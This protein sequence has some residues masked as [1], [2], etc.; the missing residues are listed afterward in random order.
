[1]T[2]RPKR[3]DHSPVAWVALG[4]WFMGNNSHTTH[5]RLALTALLILASLG[6]ALGAAGQASA[7]VFVPLPLQVGPGQQYHSIQAAIDNASNGDTIDVAPGIY[8]ETLTLDKNLTLLG[9][10]NGIP[11]CGRIATETIINASSGNLLTLQGGSAG[12][13]IDG[14]TFMGG[15]KQLQSTSGPIDDVQILNN[16]F[17]GF[18]GSAIFLNDQGK[19]ITIHQN[20]IDGS[21]TTGSGGMLHLDTDSFSGMQITNNCLFNASGRTG[22]FV[23]GSNNVDPSADRNPLIANN[24]FDGL[25]TGANLGHNA[26][27]GG[28]IT[29]NTFSNN[30]YDGLQGG[31]QHTTISFNKFHDNGRFGIDL[32]SFGSTNVN[33]G[34]Q[35]ANV[36]EN[37]FS[38]NGFSHDGAGIILS[39][40]QASGTIAT[41]VVHENNITGNRQGAIYTGSESVDLIHNWWGDATGPSGDG[42]GTGDAVSGSNIEYDPWL[43][44]PAFTSNISINGTCAQPQPSCTEVP[45]ECSERTYPLNALAGVHHGDHV[46]EDRSNDPSTG[47]NPYD[48]CGPMT[49]TIPS[50][51]HT[52]NGLSPDQWI[53]LQFSNSTDNVTCVYHDSSSHHDH[54]SSQHWDLVGCY[55]DYNGATPPDQSS[56][57]KGGDSISA[58]HVQLNITGQKPEGRANAHVNLK[59]VCGDPTPSC[60]QPVTCEQAVQQGLL[61]ADMNS[62]GSAVIHNN[63][64]TT[65]EVGIASYNMYNSLN[66]LGG[67]G[68]DTQTLYDYMLANVSKQSTSELNVEIPE[69]KAQV[70]VFCFNTTENSPITHFNQEN[71]TWY[72]GVGNFINSTFVGE[73]YCTNQT[74]PSCQQNTTTTIIVS[75][76]QAMVNG[77]N[78]V[79]TW[80]STEYWSAVIP[81][82]TW[83]WSSYYVQDPRNGAVKNFTRTFTLPGNVTDANLMIAV[84]DYYRVWLNGNLIVTNN[85]PNNFRSSGQDYLD[86]FSSYLH[87]GSNTVV[88]EV[89]NMA[90]NT[91]SPTDNPAGLLYRLNITT[92]TCGGGN[93]RS[94]C[95]D[96]II[97]QETEQCDGSAPA[98]YTCTNECTLERKPLFTCN[99]DIAYLDTAA[100]NQSVL[101]SVNTTTGIGTLSHVFPEAMRSVV[102]A[103]HNGTLYSMLPN[104]SNT[105]DLIILRADGTI[106][107][108]GPTGLS[109][110]TVAMEFA[111]NGTLYAMNENTNHLYEINTDT[112]HA[113]YLHTF[114]PDSLGVS[115]GDLAVMPN[116]TLI[117]LRADGNVYGIDLNNNYTTTLL[118][119]LGGSSFTSL[120]YVNETFYGL[121]RTNDGLYRFTLDPFNGSL[122]A[123]NVGPFDFGDATTCP[124]PVQQPTDPV[125]PILECVNAYGEGNYTAYFG[126]LN[127]NSVNITIPIGNENKITGGGLSGQDQGQPTVFTPGRT[128]YYPNASFS[129]N[130][131]GTNM[132]WTLKGP[133]GST[134]TSTASANSKACTPICGD[135][136]VEAGEQ[137]DG[138]APKGFVCTPD[139]QLKVDT[140]SVCDPNIQ[141]VSNGGFETPALASGEWDIFPNGTAGLDWNVAWATNITSFGGH[142]RP[143]LANMEIHNNV[144]GQGVNNTQYT[145]LDSDWF[146]HNLSLTG[147]PASVKIWEDLKT[148]PNATYNISFAFSPRPGTDAANNDLL[149]YWNGHLVDTISADGSSLKTTDW[150]FYNYSLVA[151]SN[152]TPIMFVDNGTPDGL[153][154]Y[155]D[156]VS[157]TCS[158]PA[159]ICG[160]GIIERGETCDDGN[161]VSGD[162]CSSTCQIE[163]ACL[164]HGQTNT[165]YYNSSYKEWYFWHYTPDNSSATTRFVFGPGTPLNNGSAQLGVDHKSRAAILTNMYSGTMLRDIQTL[166]YSTYNS[167]PDGWTVPFM[168]PA[169]T[170]VSTANSSK[171]PQLFFQPGLAYNVTNNTWQTWDALSN[172]SR[173]WYF[174][175]W[176]SSRDCSLAHPCTFNEVL[177]NFPD[178]GGIKWH[179]EMGFELGFWGTHDFTGYVD[180]FTISTNKIC[181]LNDFEPTAYCGDG[182]VNQPSE[183]CDG[184]APAGWTC[185]QQCQLQAPVIPI[186]NA[187]QI[188]QNGGFESPLVNTSQDWNIFPDGTAGLVWNV[189]W[190]SNQTTY[191]NETRPAIANAELQNLYPAEN[192]SQYAELDSDWDGPTGSL[193]GEP[194]SVTMSQVLPTIA[195]D[196]Y[197]VAFSF[198]PRPNTPASDNVLVVSWEGSPVDVISAAGGSSVNWT[199]YHLHLNAT[200]N[201][202][203]LSFTD[204]GTPDS[205]GTLLDGV[206]AVCQPR[207]PY[208]GNGI[209]DPGEQ[210]DGS[211]PKGFTCTSNCTIEVHTE[212]IPPLFTCSEGILFLDTAPSNESRLYTVNTTTGIGTLSHVFG[213]AMRSVVAANDNGT[214]YSML[215]NGSNTDGL[216]ILHDDGTI[217]NIGPTGLPGNTVAMEFA[218]DGTLYAMNQNTNGLYSVDVNTGHATLLHTFAPGVQGGDL[219]VTPDNMLVYL[220][221]DGKVYGV[222]LNDNY[223]TTLLGS[224][225]WS[226]FT[227]LGY[228]NGT[229]YGLSFNDNRMYSFTLGPFDSS[230]VAS[231]A[232]P[233]AYGDATSCPAPEPQPYVCEPGTQ[234][235]T[236]GGFEY[237]VVNNS[238]EWDI[239]PSG[240]SG[241]GWS[242]AWVPGPNTYQNE[243]RPDVANVELQHDVNGWLAKQGEQYAEL[244]SDW[245]GPN[246]S[247]SGEPAN[248]II[249]QTVPTALN[250]SY[251]LTFAFS[252]RPGS[253]ASTNTLQ[254]YF[255]GQ[256]VANITANG[257]NQTDWTTYGYNLVANSSNTTLSFVA[258]GTS[259]SLGTFLDNVSLTCGSTEPVCG[260][261]VLEQGEQCDDGNNVSGDGCSA[262]CQIETP[263]PVC[264]QQN[265]TTL[266]VSDNQTMVDGHNAVPTWVAGPWTSLPNATWIWNQTYVAEPRDG[267]THNFTRT[268]TLPGNVTGASL[269]IAADN[270]YRF[271]VN[272]ALVGADPSQDNYGSADSYTNVSSYLHAGSNTIVF[273][274]EN[275][276]W[277]TDSP[278][279]NPAGLLYRLNVTTDTCGGNGLPV[280]TPTNVTRMEAPYPASTVESA[281]QGLT[282]GGQSVRPQRSNPTQGLALE[283]THSESDFYT[284]GFGGNITVGFHYPVMNGPGPDVGV[285]ET[286][287]KTN[288]YPNETADVYASNDMVDWTFLGV[289]DNHNK[290]NGDYTINTF[291][292]GSMPYA[293]YVKIVDTTNKSLFTGNNAADG[294]DL[295]A[296]LSLQNDTYP[297]C[298]EQG[299]STC[300]QAI[301][302]GKLYGA[303]VDGT[304]YVYNNASQSFNVSMVS[305][306]VSGPALSD[307]SLVDWSTQVVN[308][309]GS[310]QYHVDIPEC[311]A[312]VMLV[313][314]HPLEGDPLYYN[315]VLDEQYNEAPY[316]GE[317]EGGQ[318]LKLT[319]LPDFPDNGRWEFSC[320][321]TG[322]TPTN[323]SWDYGNGEHATGNS[324]YSPF[325][326]VVTY[327]KTGQ[328]TVTCNATD[329]FTNLTA[330]ILVNVTPD[331]IVNTTST[332]TTNSTNE[333]NTSGNQSI[334]PLVIHSHGNGINVT[335]DQF[336]WANFCPTAA[337]SDNLGN[338]QAPIITTE[339][340]G[341]NGTGGE[342]NGTGNN[343]GNS[344]TGN[345][346]A[347]GGVPPGWQTILAIV[348]IALILAGVLGLYWYNNK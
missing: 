59:S 275:W 276:A 8:N 311:A 6:F 186:C 296:V 76:N 251:H 84:D 310:A 120:G 303:I 240:T 134:R 264:E 49:F 144:A 91:D 52:T 86:N 4:E 301:Q 160:N 196:Q 194:A 102:A 241:L 249:S 174:M 229:F 65:F 326:P 197:D 92:D 232:G 346:L 282:L 166:K 191:K 185:T 152:V 31:I 81:N 221:S 313:C 267:E 26:F 292:L 147:N 150:K 294:F 16:R 345:A 183:Q 286:T 97:N 216:V 177:S 167:T 180:N 158:T 236:N 219:A 28:D 223:T 208:C 17:V 265:V 25:D 222:D 23:D 320:M 306:G 157:T 330:S 200:M 271:W 80:V 317:Q 108:V 7:A 137:C 55:A 57:Y 98:G 61:W 182:I 192:G 211:A 184:S 176:N 246:D 175:G 63:A 136:I 327:N 259:D 261:G 239:Y 165:S 101:Y 207:E 155:L 9:N 114:M 225:G 305:Y 36:V 269:Q 142:T 318:S 149:F 297:A 58:T 143:T 71:G 10:Q 113:T 168:M 283:D 154:T 163:N 77:T 213:E 170:N 87:P 30:E 293:K 212:E 127:Q 195:G 256:L 64:N 284:L 278:T 139:C 94:Y 272:G 74:T 190:H 40:G 332:N 273:E 93:G 348:L 209:V 140:Q 159:P 141:L 189:S 171:Y 205:L 29:N 27:T 226:G 88:F 304:A 19:D 322:Y 260:N 153:G 188:V 72:H 109:G 262:T 24:L 319:L 99:G 62:D 338:N 128:P 164:V 323:Y 274:V 228:V 156:A 210:C 20:S 299:V 308:G 75:D 314:G 333:T 42:P 106:E 1:M 328:Y 46:Q 248:S 14:F 343:T 115:G 66:D 340:T 342:H 203:E 162:G 288:S 32:T 325:L 34:A 255:G 198:S 204:N 96:G 68:L 300:E 220:R 5:T 295:N 3:C 124:A 287:W 169:Y 79:P 329:G 15:N 100:S 53:T 131:D 341:T 123:S 302:D 51:I 38:G 103:D 45:K 69:C 138:S 70:D 263:P 133:D 73:S 347:Q 291:D 11:A 245:Y 206:S 117:Y 247:V 298:Q 224:I 122:V 230:L 148:M 201:G 290:S 67:W 33:R 268:F 78:A 202:S 47:N 21:S 13:V 181:E 82:A 281:H 161:N 309:S 130:F 145:E 243:T 231:K 35:Y 37:D 199:T 135:G 321:P 316:C 111:P 22:L 217:E 146:G 331:E 307:Q 215:P 116:G 244:D 289:A 334:P 125:K 104:G 44:S 110:N 324:S 227:S 242:A 193:T 121:S 60:Q 119:T 85:D 233:F 250:G 218:P 252:P 41:N 335:C 238:A 172:T 266:I 107:H 315:R 337:P 270:S 336:P 178:A 48:F 56:I 2:S 118:G 173:G 89:T 234:L 254:V 95:G 18:T 312:H 54:G 235:L 179:P 105:G 344:I 187:T 214:L 257:T 132:V 280:C 39:N 277:P 43:C 279:V 112:G 253:P 285:V 237:P 129:V 12:S 339:S 126:Y 258:N 83:I 151:T 50:T 90:A